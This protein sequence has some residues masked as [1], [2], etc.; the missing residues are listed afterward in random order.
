MI[1]IV[2]VDGPWQWRPGYFKSRIMRR[3]WWGPIAVAKLRIP[4]EEF[5]CRHDYEWVEG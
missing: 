4:Y 1:L 5:I 3:F 2:E